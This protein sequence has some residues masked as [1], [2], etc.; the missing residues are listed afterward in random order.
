MF[1]WIVIGVLALNV[2]DI[3]FEHWKRGVENIYVKLD[4]YIDEEAAE[5]AVGP[6]I[7]KKAISGVK[8]LLDIILKI[9]N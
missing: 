6:Q 2:Q 1:N 9:K 7:G 8:R 4:R 5:Q 3:S